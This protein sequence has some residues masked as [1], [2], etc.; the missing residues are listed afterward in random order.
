MLSW[1]RMDAFRLNEYSEAQGNSL[2]CTADMHQG[3]RRLGYE[4]VSFPHG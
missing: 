3:A 1:E 2:L 4:W